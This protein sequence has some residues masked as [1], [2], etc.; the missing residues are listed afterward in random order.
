MAR[1]ILASGSPRRRALLD[2]LGLEFDIFVMDV[3]EEIDA[4][5]PEASV[6]TAAIS[7][8]RA[9]AMQVEGDAF[10]L[11]ADTIGLLDGHVLLKPRDAADAQ[12]ML[13]RLSGTTHSVL[14]GVAAVRVEGGRMVEARARASRTEVTFHPLDD[15]Q[16]ADYVATGEPLDK[17]GAYAIQGTG[18]AFVSSISGSYHNVVGLPIDITLTLLTRVGYPL[19]PRLRR[20]DPVDPNQPPPEVRP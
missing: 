6:L 11:A 19:P 5:Q 17:A 10:V 8:A 12:A 15:E 7:K 3:P 9:A 18:A 4:S 16:I 2:E 20:D 13:A 1:L 14:T